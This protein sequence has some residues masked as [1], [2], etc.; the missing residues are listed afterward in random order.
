MQMNETK[1]EV[2]LKNYVLKCGLKEE[3]ASNIS[4]ILNKY[5]QNSITENERVI[6]PANLKYI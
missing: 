4:M 1:L 3:P 2:K 5:V 6:I